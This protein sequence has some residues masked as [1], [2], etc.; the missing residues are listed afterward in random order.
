M[1]ASA[2]SPLQTAL[3]ERINTASNNFNVDNDRILDI[4]KLKR[5]EVNNIKPYE[6]FSEIDKRL[7]EAENPDD[8]IGV[9]EYLWR[10]EAVGR[11]LCCTLLIC[12][13][14][15]V[16]I[17]IDLQVILISQGCTMPVMPIM[18]NYVMSSFRMIRK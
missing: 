8:K 13:I 18:P 7:L 12:W 6:I 14:L 15:Y 11:S 4:L 16:F 9:K 10:T 2:C 17:R 3:R 1:Y 5:I